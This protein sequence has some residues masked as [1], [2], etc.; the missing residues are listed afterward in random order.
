MKIMIV[1]LLFSVLALGYGA[2]QDGYTALTFIIV[3]FLIISV[4][5]YVG[6]LLID[7]YKAKNIVM[8]RNKK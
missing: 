8:N 1:Y 2:Y 3:S 5:T 4:V 7:R 6:V